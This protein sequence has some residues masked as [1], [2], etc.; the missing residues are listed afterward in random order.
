[1]SRGHPGSDP[2]GLELQRHEQTRHVVVGAYRRNQVR[3]KHSLDFGQLVT[4]PML[5]RMLGNSVRVREGRIDFDI[6]E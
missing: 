5:E 3:A 1:M 4:N 6:K 2:P